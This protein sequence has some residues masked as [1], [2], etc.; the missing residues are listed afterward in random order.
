MKAQGFT[1]ETIREIGVTERNFPK[2]AIGDVVAISQRIVEGDKSRLQ[3]FE[4][5]VIAIS[6]NGA[7]STFTVRKIG[8]DAVA[9]ERIFP[10]YSPVIEGLQVVR[11]GKVRRAKLYYMR[12]RV[13]KRARVEEMVMT[14]EQREQRAASRGTNKEAAL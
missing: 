14:R 5:D 9:V 2:V 8:A 13:G 7:S 3:V 4:G 12:K 11:K 6:N 1:R 10:F